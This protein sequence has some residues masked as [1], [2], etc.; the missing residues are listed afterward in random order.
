MGFQEM[1]DAE[2]EKAM[3][4]TPC[5]QTPMLIA[6]FILEMALRLPREECVEVLARLMI[7]HPM[8][9]YEASKRPDVASRIRSIRGL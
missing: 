7:Q 8:P 4:E 3:R 5:P 6:D 9:A 1:R 2:E